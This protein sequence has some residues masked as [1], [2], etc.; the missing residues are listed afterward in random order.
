MEQDKLID[1]LKPTKFNPENH[2][3]IQSKFP[4]KC[5]LCYR[6]YYKNEFIVFNPVK[7]KGR[8]INCKDPIVER[9]NKENTTSL[10][11]RRRKR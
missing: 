2:V 11:H 4:G 1:W 3:I 7:K 8:H 10:V 5:Q 9:R 6:K